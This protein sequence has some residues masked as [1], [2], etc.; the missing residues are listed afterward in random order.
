MLSNCGTGEDPLIVPWTTRRSTQSI[1]KE[2]NPEYSLEELMLKLKLQYF[3]HLMWRADSLENTL[4]LGKTEGRRTR[5][6]RMRWLDHWLNG[7][8]FEQTLGD[9]E[10]QGSL[11]CYNPW[12]RR[13]RDDLATKCVYTNMCIHVCMHVHI[14]GKVPF[15]CYS[16][17]TRK[18]EKTVVYLNIRWEASSF[19]KTDQNF[20]HINESPSQKFKINLSVCS[21]AQ[22]WPNLCGPPWTV[23]FQA[24]LPTEFSRQEYWSE[25]PFPPP[26]NLPD[27]GIEL[28]SLTSPTLAGIFFTTSSTKEAPQVI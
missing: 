21:V 13:V 26:G 19:K 20:K 15:V 18:R 28:T 27:P 16:K 8:E 4:M 6:D 5:S 1:L 24:P 2:I 22:S 12:G 3:G 23:A 17:F 7:H 14:Y 9:T 10:G 25:V 11:V